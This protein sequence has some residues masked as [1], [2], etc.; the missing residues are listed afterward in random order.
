MKAEPSDRSSNRLATPLSIV[1]R[2]QERGRLILLVM[3][4]GY[5]GFVVV[6]LSRGSFAFFPK[7]VVLPVLLLP[8]ILS[9]QFKRFVN[10]WCTFLA[11][12]VLFDYLRGLVFRINIFIERQP[13]AEYVIDV[14]RAILGGETM[15]ELLQRIFFNGV[16]SFEKLLTVVHA[17]HF[18]VLF[19]IGMV[20]WYWRRSQFRRFSAALLALVFTGLLVYFLVPTV[21]PWMADSYLHLIS[22]VTPFHRQV[23]NT[24]LPYIA[25]G[26]DT[27]PIAAMPSLH[28]AIPALLS[29]VVLH[30]FRARGL[31]V[32]VYTVLVFISIL[33]SAEHYLIDVLAGVV[34]AVVVYLAFYRSGWIHRFGELQ[35][36]S[37]VFRGRLVL[38]MLIV[39]ATA[40]VARAQ[41]QL[42]QMWQEEVHA[43]RRATA[44]LVTAGRA[45]YVA[46]DYESAVETLSLI[47]SDLHSARSLD[48]LASSL[49]E[50]GRDSDAEGLFERAFRAKPGSADLFIVVKTS[51]LYRHGRIDRGGVLDAI[52]RLEAMPGSRAQGAARSLR[53]MLEVQRE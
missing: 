49:L 28:A 34:L 23:Y 32:V 35:L 30:H 24:A 3:M 18:A 8:P 50:L 29:C 20:I 43:T 39:V 16:G 36:D 41:N 51:V 6:L 31:I 37:T 26:F 52:R 2:P 45:A 38:T 13:Y 11:L 10:D 12:I 1:R 7:E 9:R 27:N 19:L 47:P 25:S 33:Y 46:G 5:L 44:G 15:P 17:S 21:P 4:F 14:D 53:Q 40:L 22:D 42:T 48:L